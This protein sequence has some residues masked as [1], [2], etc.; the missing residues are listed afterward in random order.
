M[1][2]GSFFNARKRLFYFTLFYLLI[3]FVYLMFT[4]SC[5]LPI[6]KKV[7]LLSQRF[8]VQEKY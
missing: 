5:A 4:T 7:L 8:S 3:L 2:F 1:Y 6:S